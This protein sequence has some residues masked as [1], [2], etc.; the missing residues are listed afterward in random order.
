MREK[1]ESNRRIAMLI[2]GDNAQPSL[3]EKMLAETSKYGMTTIRRIYGD[4]TA[5]NMGG[6]KDKLLTNAIQP[7]Q[8]FRYTIGKNATDSAMIID[9]MDILY[10]SSVDGFC[11]VSSDSDYTRLATRIREKGFFV[12]GIG[13][14]STPRAFVNACDIFVY[15]QN[16][17][18]QEEQQAA[19]RTQKHS[20][21]KNSVIQ[22]AAPEPAPEPEATPEVESVPETGPTLDPVP[23]LKSAFEI[24]S[25]EDGWAFLGTLGHHLRQLDP[26]FDARTYGFKQLS[27]LIAAYPKVFEVKDAKSSDG[28]SVIYVRLKEG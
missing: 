16:L 9:A 25:D 4:W 18:P 3:I 14:K 8:Q 21:S 19:R 10:G 17:V 13:K 28:T 12:M 22:P 5:S 24:A 11:L 15:T 6:W 27:L 20:S 1:T 26:G 23:L 2:D 7:I